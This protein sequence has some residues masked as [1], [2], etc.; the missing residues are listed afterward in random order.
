MDVEGEIFRLVQ[1]YPDGITRSEI[2][3]KLNLL[4]TSAIDVVN[5][6]SDKGLIR[7]QREKVGKRELP[8]RA[9]TPHGWETLWFPKKKGERVGAKR[10]YED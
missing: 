7:V 10:D 1:R 6:L 3:E 2:E 5:N 9:R 8:R 4:P